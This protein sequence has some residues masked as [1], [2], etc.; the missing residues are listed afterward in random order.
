MANQEAVHPGVPEV[1]PARAL[2]S[3]S[4]TEGI[5]GGVAAVLAIIGLAGV[6]PDYLA[7]VAT[8]AVGAAL[9]SEG[10]SV[11]A[12]MTSLLPGRAVERESIGLGV[13]FQTL[14]GMAGIVLGI[15]ALIGV[16][17]TVLIPAAIVA[18]GATLLVSGGVM[19]SLNSMEI[20]L[21][22]GA[23]PFKQV[24]KDAVAAAGGVQ[25]LVGLAAITLGI[26]A[27]TGIRP[28]V[29]SL[30]A[31]LIIGASDFMNATAV[32]A[33]LTSVFGR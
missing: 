10:G 27:L 14:G 6:F 24:A 21:S 30:V 17:T 18:F 13:A 31:L 4:M 25:M 11:T 12:R 16:V 19:S 3:G 22:E 7:G 28:P 1:R 23:E 8:V 20:D 26:L 32:S 29:L 2:V 15:L 33:K 5:S 9:F